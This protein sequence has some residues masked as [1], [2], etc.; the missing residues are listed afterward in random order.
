MLKQAQANPL[1]KDA[2]T[3]GFSTG[4]GLQ[5][6]SLEPAAKLLYP[7][8]TPLRNLIPRKGRINAGAGTA[9]H[10]K[11]ITAVNPGNY[12]A[13]VSEGNR[14][15]VIDVTEKDYTRAYVGIGLE[16]SVTYEA[17]YAAEGFDDERAL[18]S[19]SLLQA[20]MI[21]EEKMILTGNGSYALGTAPTP[22]LAQV[23]TAVTGIAAGTT[24]KVAVVALTEAG[25]QRAT[26]TG[27]VP[28]FTKTN[29]DGSTDTGIAGGVS[30]ISALS[31]AAT[32]DSSHTQ[33][34]ASCAAVQG[35]F[36]YGWFFTE[37]GTLAH[38]Y[39]VGTT[40]VNTITLTTDPTNTNQAGTA[41]GLSTDNSACGLAFD[42]LLT[43]ALQGG[44]YF[45]SLD[46]ATMTADGE[47]GIVEWNTA[48]KYFWDNFRISPSRIRV[49]SQVLKDANTKI[50]SGTTN[51]V[52]R[53]QLEQGMAGQ[54]NVLAGSMVR[55]YLNP[56]ALGGAKELPIDLHP[57]MP[58][59]AVFFDLETVPYPN[60]NVPMARRIRTRQ[61]Y[62]QADWPR[63]KR[64]YQFGVYA[65]L[66][67][68]VYVPFGMG[69]ITNI[70]PG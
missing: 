16:N 41:T 9:E 51:P 5:F 60:A 14:G 13:G 58:D 28:T 22:T 37:D 4:T 25:Y 26:A 56:F 64:Q 44:G 23:T 10:W 67:L 30:A 53:I 32:T 34:K 12:F 65:D 66:M 47:G 45:K 1:R 46:A 57:N 40:R 62:Y 48:L 8:L 69:V 11:A 6:Y 29:A 36:G 15:A 18:A 49:G 27:V 43:Q 19:L 63:V 39:F 24:N 17:E 35:A 68:Q 21:A 2:T 70:L 54:A 33:L 55:S 61:D 59:G 50:L 20:L 3:Q 52:Y 42:G 7:V 38:A 31:A